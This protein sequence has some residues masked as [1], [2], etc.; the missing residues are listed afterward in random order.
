[1]EK[2][3]ACESAELQPKKKMIVT[4]RQE[5]TE[6]KEEEIRAA[7]EWALGN[8]VM[9]RRVLSAHSVDVSGIEDVLQ[10]CIAKS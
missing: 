7:I 10:H 6:K 5:E 1:M 2:V 4:V 9:H 8:G 3:V